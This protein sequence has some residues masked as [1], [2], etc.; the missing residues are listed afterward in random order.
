MVQVTY[1]LVGSSTGYGYTYPSYLRTITAT[2]SGLQHTY[3]P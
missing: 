3:L 1:L 2:P